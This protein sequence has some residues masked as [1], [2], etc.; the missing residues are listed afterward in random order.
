M[1]LVSTSTL[2]GTEGGGGRVHVRIVEDQ[3]LTIQE[4]ISQ[5]VQKVFYRQLAIL[6]CEALS[7][8]VFVI[9]GTALKLVSNFFHHGFSL[10]SGLIADSY[11][12]TVL[13]EQVADK[14]LSILKPA[15]Q[16]ASSCFSPTRFLTSFLGISAGNLLTFQQTQNRKAY[17]HLSVAICH[18]AVSLLEEVEASSESFERQGFLDQAS[19]IFSIAGTAIFETLISSDAFNPITESKK[20]PIVRDYLL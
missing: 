18:F 8:S 1:S 6:R 14:F 2:Q 10:F 15:F 19:R 11:V 3:E 17:I 9:G 5:A 12:V 16:V 7:N 4:F 13:C 20:P